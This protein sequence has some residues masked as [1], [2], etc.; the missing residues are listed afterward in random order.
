MDL[1]DDRN[2]FMALGEAPTSNFQRILFN[3]NEASVTEF[4]ESRIRI[5]HSENTYIDTS[6]SYLSFDVVHNIVGTGL[7]AG[8]GV[9][10]S[11]SG[12]S[13]YISSLQVYQIYH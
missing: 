11:A 9:H 2:V 13:A 7:N 6:A 4:Q 12:A 5:P 8:D 10:F 3:S 1:M